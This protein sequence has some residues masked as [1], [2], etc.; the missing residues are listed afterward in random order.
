M[1]KKLSEKSIFVKKKLYDKNKIWTK[2]FFGNFLMLP[3]SN[4]FRRSCEKQ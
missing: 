2:N 3:S 1:K 4:I